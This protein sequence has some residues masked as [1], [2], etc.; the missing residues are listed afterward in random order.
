[1]HKTRCLPC[2]FH[3]CSTGKKKQ[4][5][6]RTFACLFFCFDFVCFVC[7]FCSHW[8]VLFDVIM[9][10]QSHLPRLSCFNLCSPNRKNTTNV[11]PHTCIKQ[12]KSDRIFE[13]LHFARSYQPYSF[14]FDRLR[15]CLPACL[16]VFSIAILSV[17]HF[18]LSLVCCLLSAVCCPLS[19]VYC[20]FSILHS[21]W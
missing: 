14:L 7:L 15:A 12:S 10:F 16:P 8:L 11:V 1:M 6:R 13:R 3:F 5:K 2:W 19:A 20:W 9:L 21:I 17:I 4:Q 18:G